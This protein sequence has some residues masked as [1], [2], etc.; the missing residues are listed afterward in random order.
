MIDSFIHVQAISWQCA[1]LA[2]TPID[3]PTRKHTTIQ[4]VCRE[5]IRVYSCTT[6][7]L[8]YHCN[9]CSACG[10][11]YQITDIYYYYI[12]T[13]N[14]LLPLP[15]YLETIVDTS[16]KYWCCQKLR[17]SALL[18]ITSLYRSQKPTNC[19]YC[20]YYCTLEHI[21]HFKWDTIAL[22]HKKTTID[23]SNALILN[24]C[25]CTTTKRVT[26]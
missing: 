21:D 14:R 16:T 5:L 3:S 15:V 2:I 13:N 26:Y 19:R 23:N 4:H 6:I 22:L 20:H 24:H 25:M 8:Q 9:D 17:T 1:W 7:Y 11:V 18:K 10:T 12:C